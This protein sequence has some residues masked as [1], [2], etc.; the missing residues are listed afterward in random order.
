MLP[1]IWMGNAVLVLCI[2]YFV[3]DKKTNSAA[4]LGFGAT[5][6]AAVLFCAAFA[7]L[8]FSMVPAAFLTA[9]GIFQLA[10]AAIGG[11]AALVLQEGKRRLAAA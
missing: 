7:L 1:F 8:S 3:L 6:K 4:A 2:K 5:A 9:M 11:A 10:T